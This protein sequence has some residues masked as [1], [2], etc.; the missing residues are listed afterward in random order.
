MFQ[1]DHVLA[2]SQLG[3]SARLVV[4]LNCFIL[5]FSLQA[6][7]D[8]CESY[9]SW[10]RRRTLC[11]WQHFVA[12]FNLNL[13]IVVRSLEDVNEWRS[14]NNR[15]SRERRTRA[16]WKW[17][18]NSPIIYCELNNS[19]QHT[20]HTWKLSSHLTLTLLCCWGW[21][22]VEND[23]IVLLGAHKRADGVAGGRSIIWAHL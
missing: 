22:W 1:R 16:E 13:L 15:W 23:Y 17:K 12:T 7:V 8:N 10:C 11:C 5:F 20:P 6:P 21:H 4:G 18:F 19:T 9:L 3:S 2:R 14:N